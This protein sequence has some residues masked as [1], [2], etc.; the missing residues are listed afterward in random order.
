MPKKKKYDSLPISPADNPSRFVI[1]LSP[2]VSA[3]ASQKKIKL[4]SRIKRKKSVLPIANPVFS[5]E[6][7]ERRGFKKS[8]AIALKIKQ[9]AFFSLI[10]F[11]WKIIRLFFAILFRLSY[12]TGWLMAFTV[13]LII[14]FALALF[15]PAFYA[16]GEF[17]K[18]FREKLSNK[19]KNIPSALKKEKIN[20]KLIIPRPDLKSAKSALSFLI[21]TAVIIIPVKAFSFYKGFNLSAARGKVLGI[22]M[23]AVGNIISAGSALGGLRFGEAGENFSQ[24]SEDFLAA[25]NEVKK[26]NNLL[27]V[28]AGLAPDEKLRLVSEG[29]DI[30]AA[31][32]LAG[33]LGKNLSSAMDSLFSLAE[34]KPGSER[35]L[36]DILGEFAPKIN[37]AKKSSH[38]LNEALKKINADN[39]PGDQKENFLQVALAAEKTEKTLA[40]VLSLSETLYNALGGREKKR[41]LL[42]FQNNSEMRGSGGF[43]GSFAVLDMDKGKIKSLEV[44]EGGGY[45]TKGAL[46]A[47][48]R[49]PKPLSILGPR[50]FFWD[51]NWWPDWPKSAEKLMWFYE[52]SDGSTVDGCIGMTPVVIEKLLAAIGPVDMTEDYGFIINAEN[53]W[54]KTQS[55]TESDEARAGGKPKKIIGD[56]MKKIMDELPA[57]ASRENLAAIARAVESGLNDKQALIY[58]SEPELQK[59]IGRYGW[60]GKMGETAGDYLMV[61]NANI[62]GQKTDR[63]IE[64][65]IRHKAEINPDGT[66]IDTVKIIRTHNGAKGEAFTGARNVDWMRIYTPIGSE[67]LEAYGFDPVDRSLYKESYNKLA[68]DPDI[69]AGEGAAKIHEASQTKIYNELGKTVF[70]N[71][72][73]LDPGKTAEIVLKY[74]LPFKFSYEEPAGGLMAAAGNFFNPAKTEINPYSLKAEKQPGSVNSNLESVLAL[75]KNFRTIWRWPENSAI[76]DNGWIIKEGLDDDKYFAAIVEKTN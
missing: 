7:G 62:G 26:I 30:L 39:I 20:W 48:V 4:F 73:Q 6:R 17:L 8:G 9:L 10:F 32:K 5:E 59:E 22:S 71:W 21:L 44:P 69:L 61:A 16:L 2:A 64:Q 41:Y 14:N 25:E 29:K 36:M 45:D 74:R 15:K 19:A 60:D 34:K 3:P 56:L 66:I 43:I 31:G 55:I 35:N 75:P 50:W 49:S 11:I 28:L 72:S 13:K 42:V 1:D 47:L 27:F 57:R 46:T 76:M 68:D 53:F 67:L 18:I 70:A 65:T 58:S 12:G 33:E 63:V 52:H 37:E 51:A 23:D 38:E 54:V 24:A 40:D